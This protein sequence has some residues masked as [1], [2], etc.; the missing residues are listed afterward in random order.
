MTFTAEITPVNAADADLA[1]GNNTRTVTVALDC[2][3]PVAFNVKPG[4]ASNKVK[5]GFGNLPTAVLAT[6]AGQYGL[7]VTVD[8]TKIDPLSVRFGTT[9]LTWTGA[10]GS[11]ERHNKGHIT[12][13]YEPDDKTRDGDKDMVLHFGSAGSG[14]TVGDTTACVQ[15]ELVNGSGRVRFFGCDSINIRP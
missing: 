3:V 9:G 7:P 2:V 14:L 4:S 1:P 13:S 15:G 12:D 11:T 10:G 8:A 5:A 6:A